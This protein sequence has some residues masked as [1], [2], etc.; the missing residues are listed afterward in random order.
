MA[1]RRVGFC[2]AFLA[3]ACGGTPGRQQ[4]EPRSAAEAEP[5]RVV[6]PRLVITADDASSIPELMRF[7]SDNERVGRHAEAASAYDRAAEHA[8]AD[9]A[10][11]A[12]HRGGIN[13]D[14]A[15]H[16]QL[17]AER[18]EQLVAKYPE[19]RLARDGALRGMRLLAH[20]ESWK[21]LGAL[22]DGFLDRYGDLRP[23]EQIVAHSSK[24]LSLV[25]AG[26]DERASYHVEKARGI[27]ER[28]QLTAAG[29]LPKDLA[30][31][32]FALGELRRLRSERITFVPMPRNFAIEL[33]RRCQLLLDAQSA[34][35]DAMR[36][37]DAHWSAMSG[38]R[39][40]ELYQ[41]LHRDLMKVEAPTAETE[42]QRQLFEGAM[43]LRYSILLDK[44]VKMM[45]HT[46]AMAARTGLDSV[47]VD[48]T[49]KARADL[50]AARKRE[51]KALDA[52]PY[53]RAQL[54]RALDDLARKAREVEAD[55]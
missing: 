2:V 14:L 8:D 37:Y 28:E 12:L 4:G 49:R 19:H 34:Y 26:D 43:R 32:F 52:L 3:I 15:G 33:E 23:F 21:R 24:S 27:A 48:K 55:S 42:K 31:M 35:S 18:F 17:A 25:A 53:S 51:Q 36:A 22:A 20:T 6:V 5:E 30:L 41:K 40:G 29:K 54:Q 47:W 9:T 44:G 11:T 38:F 13:H 7:A 50:E 46:L 39:V 1:L 16:Y 10:A 45:D